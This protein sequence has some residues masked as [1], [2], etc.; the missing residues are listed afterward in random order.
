MVERREF[1]LAKWEAWLDTGGG[2]TAVGL[3]VTD[4]S[5]LTWS[6]VWGA[7][8]VKSQDIAKTPL[9][10]Y[11]RLG[12]NGDGGREEAADHPLHPV[13]RRSA[14]PS[15]SA[16]VFWQTLLLDYYTRGNAYAL[17][18]HGLGGVEALYPRPASR[19]T[20]RL[21]GGALTYE[22][23]Q[24]S[25][26]K[27]TYQAAEIFHLRGL[28]RDGITGMS[29]IEVFRDGIGL[30]LAYQQHAANTFRNQA[31]PSL[32]VS[33]PNM[34]L[35]REKAEEIAASLTKQAS[36]VSNSG[37]VLVA[38][39]G[40][41]FKPWGFSNRD[42]EYIGARKLSLQD[43]ARIWRVPPHKI[44]DYSESAYSNI[45]ASD[46]AYVNDSL[47]PDQVNV[48]QEVW[49][50]LLSRE[51]KGEFYAE[52][53]NSALL[54]GTPMERMQIE[55]GYVNSGVSQIDEVR[56]S[57][58]WAPVP[59]GDK[60]RVQMQNVSLEKVDEAAL[61]GKSDGTGNQNLQA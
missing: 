32:T 57:H 45:T 17:I 52:Y 26:L 12:A 40:M 27:K 53:D 30:G 5:A 24:P 43:A 20:P 8:L 46:L 14:N 61:K 11:R 19:M 59:G 47:R 42:A 4:E 21:D 16:Y 15:M 25:G 9:P 50:A 49:R 28:S 7:I 6:A 36:G 34:Q 18:V 51:D 10:L 33:T 44:A 48:E 39:G 56:L 38:Y 13:L 37:K 3:N 60:N 58:N 55:T 35:S 1:S 54:K 41:E 29:P 2:A 31:R 23:A 22:Y